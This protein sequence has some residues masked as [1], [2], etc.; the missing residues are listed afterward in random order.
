MERLVRLTVALQASGSVGMAAD[1]L[2]K[3]AGFAGAADPISQLTREFRHLRSLG[4]QIESVGGQGE[5]G[6]YRLTSV[7]NRL[8][9][10]LTLGQ[11]AALRRAAVLANRDDLARRLG[12]A[13]QPGDVPAASP[14][15]DIEGDLATVIRALRD[16]CL[17]R[18]R[19]KGTERAV[20]PESVRTANGTWYLH[21][22]EDGQQSAKN[23]VVS[24]MDDVRAD[25]PG[26]AVRPVV[27]R[28]PRLHPMSW[29]VDPP[30]DVILTADEEYAADVRR[31]LG[32]P[33]SETTT[34][35]TSELVYRVTHRAALR[36]RLYELGPRVMV[37]GP[38]AVRA[39]IIDE[40]AFMAGE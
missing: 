27:A 29:E 22:Q 2:V 14:A 4:W 24:R 6:R 19:Y 15:T 30:V 23:F 16:R 5:A 38:A 34:D 21:G 11:Q 36:S 8:R 7:D 10:K 17:L 13:D 40:L 1:D 25:R 28:H 3:V 33:S 32:E 31:W 12:L 9:V 37:V 18:F 20:H 35:G 26:T 39:E